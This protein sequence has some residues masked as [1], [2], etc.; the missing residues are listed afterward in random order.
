MNRLLF[1][2]SVVLVSVTILSAQDPHLAILPPVPAGGTGEVIDVLIVEAQMIENGQVMFF[3]PQ[4]G[5]D[6]MK[7]PPAPSIIAKVDCSWVR[8][9]GVDGKSIETAELKKRL[10]TWTA[11]VVVPADRD[12]PDPFYMKV[13]HQRTVTFMVSKKL[14]LPMLKAARVRRRWDSPRP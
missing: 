9:F 5:P 10:P 14:L 12:L 8:A 1:A 3:V 6:P 7:P 4:D 13:L 11:V 2:S